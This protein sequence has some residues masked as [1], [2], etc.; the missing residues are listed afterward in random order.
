MYVRWESNLKIILYK[1]F[2]TEL[3]SQN[4][5]R[6]GCMF[7]VVCH[8]GASDSVQSDNLKFR[9]VEVMLEK[10]YFR[11]PAVFPLQLLFQHCSIFLNYLP[12]VLCDSPDHAAYY[13]TL[14]F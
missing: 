7:A 9:S 2:S 10:V 5:E 11:V 1:V 8:G 12:S 14:G 4:L 6:Q 13:H 3:V